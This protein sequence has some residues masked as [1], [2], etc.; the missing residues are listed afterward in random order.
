MYSYKCWLKLFDR[1]YRRRC[2][3]L[4]AG[5]AAGENRFRKGT[6]PSESEEERPGFESKSFQGA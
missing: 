3:F 4:G 2:R 1:T 6:E 5:G